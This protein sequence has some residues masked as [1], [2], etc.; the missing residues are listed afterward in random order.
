MNHLFLL[1]IKIAN[2]LCHDKER[3]DFRSAA[4]EDRISQFDKQQG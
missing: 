1:V 4:Q 3:K 2:K